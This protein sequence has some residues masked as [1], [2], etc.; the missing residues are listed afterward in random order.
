MSQEIEIE[1]KNLLTIEEFEKIK[2]IFTIKENDFIKQDNHYFD[3]PGFLLKEH[4]AALR[5]RKKK[6]KFIM[7]LKE[8]AE[9]GLLE[10]HQN[11]TEDEAAEMLR[12]GK[13]LSGEIA[14]RLSKLG[15]DVD[16][17][18]YFGTLSTYRAERPYQ[19]G[20]LILDHS[21]YLSTE[22]YEIEYE[23]QDE[24]IGKAAFKQ[25]L[26][27]LDIPSRL[28]KNKVR[29]FYEQKVKEMG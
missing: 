8:P 20:L 2:D 17:I 15:I 13:P 26:T 21:C 5:I 10:T 16:A 7:T 25:L 14:Q 4:G 29:R 28:T 6:N 3:T 27:K 22:D 1:F 19:N 23:V 18:T 24:E 9:I 12:T 11:L